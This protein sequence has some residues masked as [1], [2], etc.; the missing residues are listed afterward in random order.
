MGNPQWQ[1][2]SVR[3]PATK[4]SG[5]AVSTLNSQMTRKTSHVKERGFSASRLEV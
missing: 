4:H 2:N 1:Q 3:H 5:D